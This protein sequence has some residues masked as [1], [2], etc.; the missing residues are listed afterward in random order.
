MATNAPSKTRERSLAKGKTWS[1]EATRSC[2]TCEG[3]EWSE[4]ERASFHS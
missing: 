1:C 4:L 3:E 2:T